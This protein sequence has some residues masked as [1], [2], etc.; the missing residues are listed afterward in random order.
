MNLITCGPQLGH[1]TDLLWV[2]DLKVLPCYFSAVGAVRQFERTDCS[3][4]ELV[5]ASSFLAVMQPMY[6]LCI[7]KEIL[8]SGRDFQLLVGEGLFL[9]TNYICL[10]IIIIGVPALLIVAKI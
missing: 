9:I 7:P 6:S 5:N 8:V 3:N 1:R 4:S 10:L 2:L